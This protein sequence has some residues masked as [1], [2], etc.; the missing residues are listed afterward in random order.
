MCLAYCA[1]YNLAFH[2]TADN[3]TLKIS[4]KADILFQVV[5]TEKSVFVGSVLLASYPTFAALVLPTPSRT[6]R[7]TL[8]GLSAIIVS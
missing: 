5:V 2:R 1:K 4:V 6:L 7:P 8:C 3:M